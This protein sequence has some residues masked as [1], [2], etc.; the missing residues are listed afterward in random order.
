MDHF[1]DVLASQITV[2]GLETLRAEAYAALRAAFPSSTIVQLNDLP[3]RRAEGLAAGRK[4]DESAGETGSAEPH[5]AVELIAGDA[6]PSVVPFTE[7]GLRFTADLGGQKTGF[8]CDQ[9]ESRR[10][11]ERLAA[12]PAGARPVRPRRRLRRL[13][14][15]RRRHQR[16]RGR[17]GAAAG[18]RARRGCSRTTLSTSSACDWVTADVFADLRRRERALRPGGLRS[19]A[20]GAPAPRSSNAAA[21]AYK[22]VNRLA[23]RRCAP[24]AFF[25]TFTCSGAVDATLFRQILFA[26]AV[27]AGVGLQLLQPLAAA[28]DH[29]VAVTHP[30]G[31]YLKG[32][33]AERVKRFDHD[34]RTP[35]ASFTLLAGRALAWRVASKG[36]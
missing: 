7:S 13:R 2:A 24:G 32:W 16:H 34:S 8:Y 9:R 28:P 6:V 23:L 1:G 17:V 35:F 33:W 30:Q 4:S 3:S 36:P 22:D 26:A 5:A 14:V 27:E 10:L 18:G 21:R 20:A 11:V 31:E 29:P 15:A 19:A 25:L 12:R